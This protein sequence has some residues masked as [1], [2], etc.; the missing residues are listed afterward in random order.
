MA[1]DFI[2]RE[3]VLAEIDKR[4]FESPIEETTAWMLGRRIV[5]EYPAADVAEIVRC[6]DC[7]HGALTELYGEI[8]MDCGKGYGY[9]PFD[10]F[11]ADGERCGA[12]MRE[13]VN[14]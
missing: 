5:R 10:W 6:K 2:R 3:D 14:G 8:L 13:D 12:D 11:C 4:F 1:D 9:T 7:K